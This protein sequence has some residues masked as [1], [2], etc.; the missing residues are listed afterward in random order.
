MEHKTKSFIPP[1]IRLMGAA[2][3]SVDTRILQALSRPVISHLDPAFIAMMKEIQFFI[4]YIFQTKN[5]L[6]FP[7]SGPASSA[8]EACFLN[9]I[10]ENDTVIV[11][12]NGLYGERMSDLLRVYGAKVIPI[13]QKWGESIDIHRVEETLKRNP[14]AKAVCAVHAESST[15]VLSDIESI[16]RLCHARGVLSIIDVVSSIITTPLKIDDWGIDIAYANTHKCLGGIP[17]LAPITVSD[18]AI[19]VILK[20]KTP[21]R[22]Y[23]LNF[24]QIMNNWYKQDKILRTYHFS[25]PINSLYGM[26]EALLMIYEEGLENLRKRYT[27]NGRHFTQGLEKIGLEMPVPAAIRIPILNLVKVQ[28][29][30]NQFQIIHDLYHEHGI[31]ISTGMGKNT[32]D[33][34][35]MAA[36]GKCNNIVDIDYTLAALK[37]VLKK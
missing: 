15:G 2:P 24:I 34:L 7:L 11:C 29:D 23:F 5:D 6:T 31:Q 18:R 36:M 20:R 25:A 19:D 26:H 30:W 21:V 37:I 28:P 27:E 1:K 33:F 32:A 14:D 35:R 17:G 22:S 4:R 3:S 16:G 10:E 13:S 12:E 8:M 9:V